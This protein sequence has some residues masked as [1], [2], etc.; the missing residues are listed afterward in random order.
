M[1]TPTSPM[2]PAAIAPTTLECTAVLPSMV[3]QADPVPA[4]SQTF[5]PV[6]PTELLRRMD[7]DEHPQEIKYN[8]RKTNFPDVKDIPLFPKDPEGEMEDPEGH[9]VKIQE[10]CER[11]NLREEKDKFQLLLASLQ[12]KLKNTLLCFLQ[13]PQRTLEN[14]RKFL[15]TYFSRAGVTTDPSTVWREKA[16]LL[17]QKPEEKEE[18]FVDRV[19]SLG[20]VALASNDNAE[21]VAVAFS[22]IL[23]RG[24]TYQDE[25]LIAKQQWKYNPGARPIPNQE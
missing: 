8:Y 21:E 15:Q 14:A 5:D 22:N 6:A 20:A 23:L 4:G 25:L 19:L 2:P 24:Q 16:N 17:A 13:P 12:A 10:L 3:E 11:G 7:L 1:S 9:I 18:D